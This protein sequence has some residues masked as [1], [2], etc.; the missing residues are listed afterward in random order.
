MQDYESNFDE[1]KN[2]KELYIKQTNLFEQ[3][4]FENIN[5]Q[6]IMIELQQVYLKNKFLEKT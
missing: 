1:G 4:K 2:F 5:K 6:N 3:I